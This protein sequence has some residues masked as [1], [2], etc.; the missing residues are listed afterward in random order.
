MLINKTTPAICC[1]LMIAMLIGMGGC[2]RQQSEWQK[3][4]QANTTDAYEQFLKKYPSGEFSAQAQARLKE[5]YEERD[6]Q[7]ARDADTPDA[8]QAFL[9]QYPEGKWTEEARIRVE[10]FTLA[11]TP[12]GQAPASAAGAPNPAAPGESAPG[13]GAPSASTP[14]P[15]AAASSRAQS[16][17]VKPEPHA[18][19]AEPRTRAAE[20]RTKGASGKYAVQLGA[21]KSGREAAHKRWQHLEKA[22]PTLFAGVSSKVLAKKSGGHT[23]YRLQA[24][25]MSESHARNICKALQAKSPPCVLIR[26]QR[27]T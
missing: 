1:A 7:K 21:Y 11:Q 20:E 23:L 6:W 24:V 18:K 5:M 3:T 15:A 8:Y 25:G 17:P 10:N 19:A 27:V 22:Y 2:S 9:K 4:R 12:T 16:A 14:P 26:P 13:G